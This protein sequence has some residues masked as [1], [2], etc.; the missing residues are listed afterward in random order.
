ML[1]GLF[2]ARNIDGYSGTWQSLNERSSHTSNEN[3]EANNEKKKKE[4]KANQKTF[5][6][7][8]IIY[9]HMKWKF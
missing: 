8:L 3:I 1:L 5:T 9:V 4:K 7:L 6:L 2:G